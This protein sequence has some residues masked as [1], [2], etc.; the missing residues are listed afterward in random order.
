MPILLLIILAVLLVATLLG[1]LAGQE[2]RG[3]RRGVIMA[4]AVLAPLLVGLPVKAFA[5]LLVLTGQPIGSNGE[6]G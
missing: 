1:A 4:A 5:L 6:F 2:L 3:A